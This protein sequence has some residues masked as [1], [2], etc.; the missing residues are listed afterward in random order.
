M[1]FY[2]YKIIFRENVKEEQVKLSVLEIRT[3]HLFVQ[4]KH[5]QQYSPA[6]Q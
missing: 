5:T 1:L 6:I 2:L 4:D 3:T